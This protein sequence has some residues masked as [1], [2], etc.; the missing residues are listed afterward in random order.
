MKKGFYFLSILF[1]TLSIDAL[2]QD[3]IKARHETDDQ[4]S[5]DVLF[6]AIPGTTPSVGSFKVTANGQ[7]I[8]IVAVTPLPAPSY[9]ITFS[10]PLPVDPDPVIVTYISNG[11]SVTSE[12]NRSVLCTDF[13]WETNTKPTPPCAP[14]DPI[15][16]MVFSVVPGARNS[17]QFELYKVKGRIEWNDPAKTVSKIAAYES[18]ESGIRSTGTNYITFD[19][20]LDNFTYPADDKQSSY[21]SEW[22]VSIDGVESCV[23]TNPNQIITYTSHNVDDKGNGKL[24]FNPIVPNTDEVCLNDEA[25]VQFKDESLLNNV[26]SPTQPN[27]EGRWVRVIYGDPSRAAGDRIP[28]VYINGIQITDDKGAFINPNGAGNLTLTSEGIIFTGSGA[29]I[30]GVKYF[31]APVTGPVVSFLP[32]TTEST[33]AG[34]ANRHPGD[35]FIVRMEYWNICNSYDGIGN[36]S[37]NERSIENDITIIDIPEP[38]V[39]D[40]VEICYD[41]E[42]GN[43]SVQGIEKST[44]I[45]WYDD[46]PAEGG[47]I[48]N[49][50]LGKNSSL[51]SAKG[52][53]DSSKVGIYSVWATQISGAYNSCEGEAVETFITVRNPLSQPGEI[54]GPQE[55][56]N[57]EANV[58]FELTEAEGSS[59]YGGNW[60]YLWSHSGGNG[61]SFDNK[62][63]QRVSVDF[64]ISSFSEVS[65]TRTIKVVKKYKNDPS[66]AGESRTFEVTIYNSSLGGVISSDNEICAGESTGNLTLTGHRGKVLTWQRQYNGGGFAD[67]AGTGGFITYGEMLN[68]AGK[69]EYRAVVKNGTCSPVHSTSSVITV[70]PV[71]QQPV[72]T[73]YGNSYATC[74]DREDIR[75]KASN[76]G[77]TGRT[78][79]WYKA[80]DLDNPVQSG[81]SDE[82][83][84]SSVEQS[85]DYVVKVA[86]VSPSNCESLLSD[87]VAVT[88]NSLPSA[89]ASGGGS[90]CAGNPA[91][92]IIWEL[93]GVAP[94]NFTISVTG[95]PDIVVNDHNKSTYA[96]AA[97]AP[98]I[99][100]EY[101]MISLIDAGGCATGSLGEVVTVTIGGTPPVVENISTSIGT[102]CDDGSSTVIPAITLDL[103]HQDTYN[104]V[105]DIN[106]GTSKSLT[107]TT[108]VNGVYKLE[109][110]YKAAPFNS[111]PGKYVYNLI[112]I[113]NTTTGCLSP[114]N[115]S[116]DVVINTRP[117]LPANPQDDFICSDSDTGAAL[118][119]ENPG[120]GYSMKW[121]TSFSS[122][123]TNVPVTAADGIISGAANNVFTPS[124]SATAI[125]YAAVQNNATG[126]LSNDAVAVKQ[127]QDPAPAA[128]ADIDGDPSNNITCTAEFMLE[129]NSTSLGETGTW[130][131]PEGVIFSDFHNPAATV[132]NLPEGKTTL[133]WTVTSANGICTPAIDA[134]TIERFPLPA[135][136]DPEPVVCAEGSQLQVTGINLPAEYKDLVTG[137]T[138]SP[139]MEVSWFTNPER[140][141]PVY[142]P[143]NYTANNLKAKVIYTRVINVISNCLTEGTV[144][145]N[146]LQLPEA[147]NITDELCE[148]ELNSNRIADVDLTAYNDRITGSASLSERAVAWFSNASHT[149]AIPD[150]E[151]VK[152]NNNDIFYA[153]VTDIS[154]PALCSSEA[155]LKFTVNHLPEDNPISGPTV[156]CAGSTIQLYQIE[157]SLDPGTS[158]E[159]KIPEEF[160]QFGSVGKEDFFVLLNFPT[161]GTAELQVREIS[162][163]GCAGNVQML[164]IEV[165]D[166]PKPL[167]IFPEDPE[168]CENEA[169]V[170]FTTEQLANTTY[171]WTVPAGASIIK[172]QGTHEIVVNFGLF[173]GNVSVVPTSA[174]GNCAGASAT[175]S[176]TISPRPQ[177][178]TE[179]GTTICSD[180]ISGITLSYLASGTSATGYNITSISIAPGLEGG[181]N[182]AVIG[183]SLP[184]DVIYNDIYTNKAGRPLKVSYT[185]QPVSRQG[186]S[187]SSTVISLTINPEPVLSASLNKERCSG[188]AA[189]IILAAAGGSISA[190]SYNILSV[191]DGGLLADS[192]NATFSGTFPYN[193]V[194]ANF[195]QNERYRNYTANPVD[196]LYEVAPVSQGCVGK[197]SFVVLTVSPEPVGSDVITKAICSG[198]VMEIQLQEIINK[199]N[200]VE[201]RF[202]WAATYGPDIKGG[203]YSGTGNISETLQNTGTTQQNVVYTVTPKAATADFCTGETFTITVPVN[204]EVQAEDQN[205]T[206]CSSES[207]V[208]LTALEKA[209]TAGKN[210]KV[211]WFSDA[212]ATIKVANPQDFDVKGQRTIY[213]VVSEDSCSKVAKVHYTLT[214]ISVSTKGVISDY[215]GYDVSCNG[216]SDAAVKFVATG[217][218]APYIYVLN[219]MPSNTSGR[220]SGEFTGLSA[221]SYTVTVSDANGCSSEKAEPAI[222][223]EPL[224]LSAGVVFGE[225]N[226]CS[227]S[228][229]P[230]FIQISAPIGGT[231][232]YTFSWEVSTDG[233]SFTK[234][235]GS[236]ADSSEY[237]AVEPD[238]NNGEGAYYFR[239]VVNS[240]ASCTAVASNIIKVTVNALPTGDFRFKDTDGSPISEICAGEPFL[241]EFDFGSGK[242][243]YTFEYHDDKGN[244]YSDGYGSST[245]P[246]LINFDEVKSTTT[247]TLDRVTD[248]YGCQLN[249]PLNI[250]HT[251]NIIDIDAEF[252]VAGPGDA[253]S[254]ST[255][256][257]K[258]NQVKGITYTWRWFDGSADSTY[259]ATTTEANKKVAH[260]FNNGSPT[261]TINYEV[262]LIAKGTSASG[263]VCEQRSHE[264][265][266][267]YPK[268]QAN[269]FARNP[270]S[271]G[272]EEI[273]FVN[274]SLGA[275]QH[276][277]FYRELGNTG[278]E[279][280]VQTTLN[281]SFNIVNTGPNNP[282]VYEVVYTGSTGQGGGNICSDTQVVQVEVYKKVGPDFTFSP[283]PPAYIN[284]SSFITF[285]NT[286]VPGDDTENFSYQWDFGDGLAQDVA[287]PEVVEYK[288]PGQKIV[289]L[290]VVNNAAPGQC[291][292]TITR[293]VNI[294]NVPITADF[295][296]SSKSACRNDDI[297]IINQSTGE[298]NEY[299]WEI[300]DEHN[301]LVHKHMDVTNAESK[302]MNS[303]FDYKANRAGVYSVHLTARN[304][305]SG[306]S[307]TMIKNKAFEI[308]ETPVASFDTRPDMIFIPDQPLV[309]LNYSDNANKYSWNFGDGSAGSSAF[310][311]EHHYHQGGTYNVT[312]VA[313]AL[314]AGGLTCSDTLTRQVVA[315]SGADYQLPNAFSPSPHG[316]SGDGRI[317]REEDNDIFLPITKGVEE[318][319]MAIYSRW[320]DLI[321]QSSDFN[322]GWDGYD[323]HGKLLPAGVYVYQLNLRFSNGQRKKIAGDVMLIQ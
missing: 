275:S 221:G 157:P 112:S 190:D 171:A 93:I 270:A 161:P 267:I 216:A 3:L 271:C 27:N 71:P 37:K 106:G 250:S 312:L 29:D 255:I 229:P 308:Y 132:T 114:V 173:G 215:N 207:I 20:D 117:E 296:I 136:I 138:G 125:Y 108:D 281:A 269:I 181:E 48:I 142:D 214:T 305:Y 80:D 198:E 299:T 228:L 122:P 51:L 105:Y 176:V 82:L 274:L 153:R 99:T 160:T 199:N 297:T 159:W 317:K 262:V 60:E 265:V 85:G 26:D 6:N 254:P 233:K 45:R 163:N 293:M 33:A 304:I 104:L 277:W 50:P 56:C 8:T 11:T 282:Q 167:K 209:V 177:M 261:T 187:G 164:K 323:K 318:F 120:A 287:N 258:Y 204:L 212:A 310:E 100:T 242:S 194:A 19:A 220:T 184:A 133:T 165:V 238:F 78:F 103:D 146:V 236:T 192:A 43:F 284:G 18:E 47:N 264:K 290:R 42:V 128:I 162:P 24:K 115:N 257:F 151:H 185:I 168:L 140:T 148:D 166:A 154:N 54:E 314:Y 298:A 237:D 232:N 309:T 195:L 197:P 44:E 300:Y 30:F 302:K 321:F 38:P 2:G 301:V 223:N 81:V 137:T 218:T 311:P 5:V 316:P 126:C 150:P 40:P 210:N 13:E 31:P 239:R 248:M 102:V 89:T 92:D 234:A 49:N 283:D 46:N 73:A 101:K 14:V 201:S 118:S 178:D 65:T 292:V 69:Y 285:T 72:I 9:R 94:F 34:F 188:E 59:P 63:G 36:V 249:T 244:T 266:T 227:G 135:A 288:K 15:N 55:V 158:Y 230:R 57:N 109:S 225:P 124:T 205:I 68:K 224:P 144:T 52:I 291:D 245:T 67:I 110:D 303:S 79:T 169:G 240:G 289:T 193:K 307:R 313:S 211:E 219:E 111:T 61:V 268:V 123:Y 196:V 149:V 134:I 119:V 130:A 294:Q 252:S 186:C 16:K 172:G 83:I 222:V 62:T 206:L 280:Q 96:I 97:P 260:T 189:D 286:S 145:F 58:I 170:V 113:S 32:V 278:Q 200:A 39:A 95:Q 121:F 175:T 259:T 90:V 319:H 86:G 203:M 272:D 131:G 76:A 320:G 17:S 174:G 180:N 217:G 139:N 295:T 306:D 191:N 279:E 88:I 25:D 77:G 231:G 87:P 23:P 141:I 183:K 107:F 256:E 28:N 41:E 116:V 322:V 235:S 202:S 64:N 182:N 7:S 241:I 66:C 147:V 152:V 226:L 98:E 251:I 70:N 84:L 276:R 179:L 21:T 243:G 129:A 315:Q 247:F 208:D 273:Q 12:N 246:V 253:C 156:Q 35:K 53:V 213:A 155:T 91:P 4:R 22:R 10:S 263:T 75:L 74:E 127:I 143:E 1:F